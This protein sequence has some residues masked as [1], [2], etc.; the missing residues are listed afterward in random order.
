MLKKISEIPTRITIATII[1]GLFIFM[2][3]IT[4]SFS[5]PVIIFI[6]IAGI[7]IGLNSFARHKVIWGVIS[8]LSAIYLTSMFSLFIITGLQ[9]DILIPFVTLV[10]SYLLFIAVSYSTN[11]SQYAI[12]NRWL[13]SLLG[14]SLNGTMQLFM[15]VWFNHLLIIMIFGVLINFVFAI[16]W[17]KIG[18]GVKVIEPNITKVDSEELFKI[19]KYLNEDNYEIIYNE[20]RKEYDFVDNI[21]NIKLATLYFIKDNF[22]IKNE[23]HF[24]RK[25]FKQSYMFE[26]LEYGDKGFNRRNA[27][28]FL[29]KE[30]VKNQ[31]NNSFLI[32]I[33]VNTFDKSNVERIKIK[34]TNEEISFGFIKSKKINKTLSSNIINIFYTLKAEP[35]K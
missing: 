12:R 9:I 3:Y 24:V 5:I 20:K 30:V 31:S 1:F 13:G 35:I 8:L 25:Y 17:F 29:M 10:I 28:P 15:I 27:Y 33:Q 11:N 26:N 34:D 23:D 18:K 22:S 4:N 14:L 21:N 16:F 32:L 7:L 2:L 6:T 19:N